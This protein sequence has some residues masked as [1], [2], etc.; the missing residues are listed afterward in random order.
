[1]NNPHEKAMPLELCTNVCS[2]MSWVD[3]EMT[4]LPG[5]F[6]YCCDLQE[7]AAVLEEISSLGLAA[8]AGL[9]QVTQVP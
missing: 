2:A 3:W 9:V 5:G 7:A 4:D 8:P 1:M 6:M